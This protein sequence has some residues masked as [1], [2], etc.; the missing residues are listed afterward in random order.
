MCCALIYKLSKIESTVNIVKMLKNSFRYCNHNNACHNHTIIRSL[1]FN[2]Y[3]YGGG[4]G[5]IESLPMV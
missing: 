3:S 2:V 1:C 5:G 4:G